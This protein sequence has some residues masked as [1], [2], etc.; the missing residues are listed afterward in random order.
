MFVGRISESVLENWTDIG[1]IWKSVLRAFGYA[2]KRR[3][4]QR[5]KLFGHWMRAA[6]PVRVLVLIS[7]CLP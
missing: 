4:Q 7:T 2:A 3:G 6:G 5:E 1:R